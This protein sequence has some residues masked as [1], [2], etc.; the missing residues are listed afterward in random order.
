MGSGIKEQHPIERIVVWNRTDGGP[1]IAER[2][3]GASIKLLD[4]QRQVVWEGQITDTSTPMWRGPWMARAP[5]HS[6]AAW[7]DYSQDGFPAANL[8]T[9]PIAG[10]KRLGRGWRVGT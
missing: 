8:V 1:A 3:K 2:L 9:P 10:A 5:S 6:A 7:A 4:A